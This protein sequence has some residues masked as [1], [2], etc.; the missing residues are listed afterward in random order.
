MKMLE[1]ERKFL[2]KNLSFKE[3]SFANKRI[4]QGYLNSE[5]SRTVRVRIYGEQ[6]FLTIKGAPD[7]SGTTRFEWE[8]SIDFTEA[9]MLLNI[10]EAGVIDKTRYLFRA[11]DKVFE[12]DEFYG[13]NEGL[14]VAEIE[15]SSADE[16]F[17]KPDWLGM[18]V[19][20]DTKY[21]NSQLANKPFLKWTE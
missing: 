11:A 12:I 8:K 1:I 14:V 18:E 3:K 19:T 6:G 17:E 21:Y 2:V 4:I 15:L 20:G 5:P 16:T 7:A 10:C 13:E 9:K